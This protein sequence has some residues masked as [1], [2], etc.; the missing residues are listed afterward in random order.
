MASARRRRLLQLSPEQPYLPGAALAASPLRQRR[1]LAL[2]FAC[3]A[4]QMEKG[5]VHS[6]LTRVVWELN[7]VTKASGGTRF[8]SGSHKAAFIPP[9]EVR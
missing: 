7:P 9:E 6:G 5:R 3:A 8:L 1:R 2:T 4:L